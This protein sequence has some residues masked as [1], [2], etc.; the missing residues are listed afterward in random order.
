MTWKSILQVRQYQY[1]NRC[2]KSHKSPMQLSTEFKAL[3]HLQRLNLSSNP[4][5]TINV[6]MLPP[7]LVHLTLSGCELV[8]LPDSIQSLKSLQ[9]LD[10]GANS[11][12][13]IDVVFAGCP[14][15]LHVGA[16][17]N[18]ISALPTAAGASNIVSLD[19]SHNSFTDFEACTTSVISL[20]PKIQSLHLGGNPIC[21]IPRYE[22]HLNPPRAPF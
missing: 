22:G 21:L 14:N 6:Q 9:V 11:I 4:L 13:C 7:N 17:Y 16:A 18:N 3:V 15:L 20:G 5:N 10:I 1:V 8:E 19:L 2:H 12:S